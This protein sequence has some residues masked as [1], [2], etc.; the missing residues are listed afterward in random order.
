MEVPNILFVSETRDET[1]P[2]LRP[3]G[4]LTDGKL[5]R[6]LNVLRR[7]A[8]GPA[9]VQVHSHRR[10]QAGG[11]I[12]WRGLHLLTWPCAVDRDALA[13][14]GID[15]ASPSGSQALVLFANVPLSDEAWKLL[16]ERDVV[17]ASAGEL[18]AATM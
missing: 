6:N 10:K 1:D 8:M 2:E 13:A 12:A 17:A 11:G 9:S 5:L 4:P 16:E 18:I 14:S 3:T 7:I 15:V